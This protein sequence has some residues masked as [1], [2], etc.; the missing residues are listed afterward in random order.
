MNLGALWLSADD[1][2]TTY[3]R[4]FTHGKL[5]GPLFNDLQVPW[6]RIHR[7]VDFASEYSGNVEAQKEPRVRRNVE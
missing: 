7:E 3:D 5:F 4:R 6:V 1:A 2:S